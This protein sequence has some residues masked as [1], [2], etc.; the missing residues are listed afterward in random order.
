MV[1][2]ERGTINIVNKK[3]LHVPINVFFVTKNQ[4]L[5]GPEPI[6]YAFECVNTIYVDH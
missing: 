4:F 2:L 6:K 1:K 3:I 5:V